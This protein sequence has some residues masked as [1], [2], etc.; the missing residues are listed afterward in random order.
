VEDTR[1]KKE[2]F[3]DGK[4]I[5]EL[6]S[7]KKSLFVGRNRERYALCVNGKD[8]PCYGSKGAM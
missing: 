6:I 4:K 3:I 8:S 7:D 5:S 2:T 1:K